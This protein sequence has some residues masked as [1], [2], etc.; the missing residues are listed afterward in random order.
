MTA[1]VLDDSID[2]G[3]ALRDTT[4]VA[5]P[6][7]LMPVLLSLIPIVCSLILNLCPLVPDP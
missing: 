6:G 1:L 5:V 3:M 4:L 7:S 2:F